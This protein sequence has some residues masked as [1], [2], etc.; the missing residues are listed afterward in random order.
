M[1]IINLIT[2]GTSTMK[3]KH[4]TKALAAT[5]LLSTT[6]LT[7]ALTVS[8]KTAR[9]AASTGL[10]HQNLTLTILPGSRLGPDGKMHDTYSPADE[11]IVA[12]VPT[13]ISIDNYDTGTHSFTSSALGL[14]IQV[15]ASKKN[16]VPAVTDYTFTPKKTGDFTWL[17]IDKCDG[18]ANGWAMRHNGYM[19]GT[20]DIVPNHNKI[21]YVYL[22]I[23]DGL[24]YAAADKQLHDSY[25]PADFTVQR[26]IPVKVTVTNFDTGNHSMTSSTLGLNQVMKG[27]KKEGV[28]TVTTFTFAP[29]KDGKFAW[30]CVIPC[31]GGPTGWAM[32]HDGYMSG[33]ITVQ[34]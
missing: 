20:L 4:V 11:T 27:A 6:V 14:S 15:K 32:T 34:N 10:K 1:K 16:G 28:P 33:S 9:A 7:G 21:Q 24:Q 3:V 22:T 12:G 19:M 17:C 30:R 23:K 25:S 13:T 31:D 8:A 26:G 5:A 18:A 2:K 29:K